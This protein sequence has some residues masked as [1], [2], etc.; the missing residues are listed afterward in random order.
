MMSRVAVHGIDHIYLSV[1]ELVASRAFHD[2]MMPSFGFE[3]LSRAKTVA[4][5]AFD[6]RPTGRLLPLPGDRPCR[7]FADPNSIKL[8]I[9][10]RTWEDASR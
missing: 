3:K 10:Y 2:R 5:A 1:A 7:D 4:F 9:A 8:E 6:S